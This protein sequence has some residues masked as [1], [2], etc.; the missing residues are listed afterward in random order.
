MDAYEVGLKAKFLDNA[1]TLNV[2]GFHEEFTNFQ[3]LEFTGAQFTTF[4]VPLAKS[5]GVELKRF[6]V[7]AT[8]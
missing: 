1:V 8:I 2:A 4:N 3:V 7:P 6:F 5:T